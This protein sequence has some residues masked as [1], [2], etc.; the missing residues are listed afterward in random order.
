M[1]CDR[2]LLRSLLP[3]LSSESKKTLVLD[4]DETLVHS[5][6][7]YIEKATLSLKV[8]I[9]S[10]S[11]RLYVL[12]RP[13]AKEFLEGMSKLF[14]LVIF[15][16]S[17]R[18]YADCVIDRL[19]PKR[20]IV[21]RLYREHCVQTRRGFIKDLSLLGR[22]LKNVVIV[23]NSSLAYEWNVENAVPIESWVG[24]M[25][26]S[27]LVKVGRLLEEL[28]WVDDVRKYLCLLDKYDYQPIIDRI[29]LNSN[30]SK[31]SSMK[32][33]K[34]EENVIDEKRR[35]DEIRTDKR[36]SKRLIS[37][38]YEMSRYN[39]KV[40]NENRWKEIVETPINAKNKFENKTVLSTISN[41]AYEQPNV[42]NR[43][44]DIKTDIKKNIRTYEVYN[45]K[46]ENYMPTLNLKALHS[47][48]AQELTRNS[49][50]NFEG[51][52]RQALTERRPYVPSTH[53]RNRL[54]ED[55]E[56]IYFNDKDSY[57]Q[58]ALR[59]M[60]MNNQLIE[61][62]RAV[63]S[64]YNDN[65]RRSKPMDNMRNSIS[66]QSS[67]RQSV[68]ENRNEERYRATNNFIF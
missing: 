38:R 6:S 53:E 22:N 14:E 4:L 57:R 3:P 7:T 46:Q 16:A 28:V 45:H 44:Y 59:L 29:R 62:I 9:N 49:S 10:R 65:I 2:S 18:P 68:L 34:V 66:T 20:L 24:S 15:T 52:W 36:E 11:T 25:S 35:R 32:R 51:R 63:T 8:T 48:R 43:D 1:Q 61:K 33:L 5:T 54:V 60:Q 64:P 58:R 55:K 37:S 12:F 23:D 21:H 47:P 39:E 50:N 41:K 42:D 56:N 17:Q 40:E 67:S 19:D 30:K 27:S 31:M 26:D 13:G